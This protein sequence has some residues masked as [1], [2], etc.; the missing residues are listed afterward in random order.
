[1]GRWRSRGMFDGL[2]RELAELQRGVT[3]S[4]PVELD[5]QEYYDRLCPW[6]ECGF[7]FKVLFADWKEKV[8]D[9]VAYCAFCRH[10]ARAQEFDTPAQGAY[11]NQAGLS[12]VGRRIDRGLRNSARPFG[13]RRLAGGLV[14]LSMRMEA[15]TPAHIVSVSP[16]A[17][18][19]MTL[20]VACE[21]CG[22]R[23]AVIGTA[24]FCP[25]CGHNSANHLFDQ[26]LASIRASMTALLQTREAIPDPDLA[27]ETVRHLT[28]Y[29]LGSLVT[30]F[31]RFAE[32]RYPELPNPTKTPN[33]NAF[34]RLYDGTQLWSGAGGQ[35]YTRHLDQ[36]EMADLQRL[37]QQRHILAHRE[38]IVD[39]TYIQNSGDATY[40][41]GQRLVVRDAAVFRLAE[42]LEK[43]VAG[44]RK[45]LPA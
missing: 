13:H 14:S 17:E 18:A 34:Q 32:A 30:A 12:E 22:C 31:Q 37:F 36:A 7:A 16:S 42:L 5:E 15:T 3:I 45:D 8:S 44:L 25:A 29:S 24:Y 10:E 40:K 19:A 27:A 43:L 39:A 2:R 33:R 11:L 28:E 1:M 6:T 20:R 38:G 23:F 9:E 26:S 41:L 4:V 35:P 21:S